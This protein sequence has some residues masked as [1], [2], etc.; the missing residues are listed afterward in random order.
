MSVGEREFAVRPYLHALRPHQW[1]KNVLV[2][3][4][5][6]AGH[7]F[8]TG[9]LITILIAFISFSLGASGIYLIN[10]M[11]D[12]PHDR[13]HPDKRHR[14]I[15]AGLVPIR[16]AVAL[17]GI[18]AV[19]SIGLAFLLPW[20]YLLTLVAY[21]GLSL[22][23]SV[24][25]KRKMMI[26]VVALAALYGIRVVAGSA[27]TDIFLSHWLVAFCFFLFLNL[28]LIKRTTEMMI[29]PLEIDEK[30]KGRN[31]LRTDLQ[32]ITGLATSAGF[33]SVLVL[34]LYISSPEVQVLYHHP[35]LLWGICVILVYWLGRVALLAG[36][37]EMKSDPVM[38]ALTDTISVLAGL[39]VGAVFLFAL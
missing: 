3:L 11:L 21:F 33:V 9:A 15:A 6:I 1:L 24:Y 36:R 30:I 26:D 37:G 17:L 4:P 34:A 31:Y 2:A 23:Y 14:S 22:S 10:D 25:L 20:A 8:N 7:N 27:A 29:L 38:F 13:A 5:A 16:H 28:A 12:L 35:D 39:L 18:V 32:T 19:G